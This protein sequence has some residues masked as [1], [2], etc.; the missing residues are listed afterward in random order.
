MISI[1]NLWNELKSA[2]AKMSLANEFEH[3]SGTVAETTIS[4]LQ[5]ASRWLQTHLEVGIVGEGSAT[6]D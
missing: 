5:E 3:S 1:E 6:K 2:I 4:Q